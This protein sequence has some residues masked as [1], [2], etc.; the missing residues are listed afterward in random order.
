MKKEILTLTFIFM[1][2]AAVVPM[3]PIG[4]AKKSDK[5]LFKDDFKKPSLKDWTTVFG[6][7]TVQNEKL[8]QT[9]QSQG[10]DWYQRPAIVADFNVYDSFRIE[11]KLNHVSGGSVAILFRYQD[12]GNTLFV[13][14]HEGINIIIGNVVGGTEYNNWYDFSYSKGTEYDVAIEVQ[15]AK[16]D[17]YVDGALIASN[18]KWGSAYSSGKIGFDTWFASV[19][20]DDVVVRTGKVSKAKSEF[21]LS[22]SYSDEFKKNTLGDNWVF[23]NPSPNPSGQSYSLTANPGF[24]TMTTTGPNDLIGTTDTAP[25]IM[26]SAPD[27]DYQIVV[28]LLAN[29]DAEM[30]HAGILVYQDVNNFVRLLR[31]KNQDSVGISQQNN[32]AYGWSFM[33]FSGSDLVLRLTK[34][35]QT[36]KGEYSTDGIDFVSVGILENPFTP[37]SIGLTVVSTPTDNVFSADF[38]Y[39]RVYAR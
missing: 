21:K 37:N 6:T 2:L 16:I 35:G 15:G 23:I 1:L 11:T 31:D 24:L 33:P 36:Y 10:G 19:T 26:Q 9:D 30:E 28:H 17:L 34:I 7:W 14:F 29:P 25:K 38:D 22:Q 12:M 8:T 18:D 3:M 13:I 5:T 4:T 32:G 39:F 20:V 27:G